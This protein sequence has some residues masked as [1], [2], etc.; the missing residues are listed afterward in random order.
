MEQV[1]GA[2]VVHTDDFFLPPDRRAADWDTQPAGNMDLARL[3]REV[4]DPLRAGRAAAYRPYSCQSGQYGGETALRPA[5][6][7][8]V[9]GS[10]SL[11]PSLRARYEIGVFL[12]CPPE[13]QADRL[14]AREGAHFA[15]FEA[16][17]IPFEER[18]FAR[19]G[20]QQ[21]AS[22]VLDTRDLF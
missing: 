2:Q 6:L 3:A 19:C 22:L 13:T 16:R 12:T 5:P 4:L 7:T 17:W 10:Y 20:V 21:A 8:V 9:E 14:R 11:H 1:L 15:A 18:Y